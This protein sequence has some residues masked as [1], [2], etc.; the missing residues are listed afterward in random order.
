[1]PE[2]HVQC[3]RYWA[4]ASARQYPMGA[5]NIMNR[6]T[7]LMLTGVLGL[8]ALPQ[9]GFAQSNPWIG[10][11]KLNLAKSTF[12]SGAPPRSQTS[13]VEAV[14]QGIKIANVGVD[15]KGNPVKN[16]VQFFNDGQ[17]HPVTGAESVLATLTYDAIS[18]KE[19]NN[20][21]WWDIRTKA[22]KVVQV[23]VNEMAPDGKTWTLTMVGVAPKGQQIYNVLVRDKQ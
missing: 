18:D 3:Q 5:G 21:T 1:M 9:V 15:A 17:S 10:T 13:T 19:V 7:T 4:I 16:V 8:A 12:S 11:W 22:G 2:I 6:R 23:V 14:G 20:S